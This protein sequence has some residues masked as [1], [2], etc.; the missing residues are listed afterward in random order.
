MRSQGRE[1]PRGQTGLTACQRTFFARPVELVC[2]T[3]RST[4]RTSRSWTPVRPGPRGRF[5]AVC[6]G[7]ASVKWCVRGP[8]STELSASA[9]ERGTQQYTALDLSIRGTLGSAGVLTRAAGCARHRTTVFWD[10]HQLSQGSSAHA[11]THSLDARA[12]AEGS[13]ASADRAA[14]AQTRRR[15]KRRLVYVVRASSFQCAG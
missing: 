9:L 12:G 8:G 3:C 5:C 1:V 11:R 10:G 13:G 4:R 6:C 15:R 7:C 14:Q 2:D